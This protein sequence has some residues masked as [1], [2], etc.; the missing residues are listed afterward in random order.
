MTTEAIEFVVDAAL[1]HLADLIA[2]RRDERN[3]Y[4][5]APSTLRVETELVVRATT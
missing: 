5:R 3:R 1:L 2:A 4:A